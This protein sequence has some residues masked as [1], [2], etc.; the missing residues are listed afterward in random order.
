M[1][2]QQ[3][4]VFAGNL[5][6]PGLVQHDMVVS[7]Q[8][9][10]IA[11][12]SPMS[13]KV[14]GSDDIDARRYMVIPGLIDIHNHGAVGEGFMSDCTEK[15]RSF[16]AS[17]GTTALLA[18][19]YPSGQREEFLAGIKQLRQR[20]AE[21]K[22]KEGTQILGIYCEGPF[23]EPSL[24]AQ[25]PE[26]CWPINN[27]NMTA[28]LETAGEDLRILALSPELSGAEDLIKQAVSRGVIVA[29]AH[30]RAGVEDMKR[31]YRAGLSHMTHIF[32]ATERPEPI[33]GKGVLGVGPD[34]FSLT[35][36]GMTAEVLADR[37]G[38]HVSPYWLNIL[39]RCKSKDKI[40]LISD[41]T[42]IAG[43]QPGVYPQRNGSKLILR[44]G[45]D[46][47]WVES[48]TKKGLAGSAMT[49]RDG[50]V[51]LMRHM[52]MPIE[53]AIECASLTPARIL[54]LQRKK[55]SIEPGKDADLVVLDEQLNVVLTMIAGEV[56][57]KET[58]V[59]G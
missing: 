40:A 51:N 8:N 57:F 56:V 23:L 39:F 5:V 17:K 31:A 37:Q 26:L 3:I 1:N 48:K 22:P 55:G 27:E 34:E 35:C 21:Q 24:G 44:D 16:L 41:S 52:Q 50:L 53:E 18:T 6:N 45:E 29:A 9:S 15:A 33:A 13:E 20:I 7:V 25:M 36:D 30:S 58:A 28:V 54:G 10:K 19:T 47:G 4:Q 32:N 12:V 14:P 49:I 46:V 38:Y 43:Q 2:K 59:D 11:G 42:S